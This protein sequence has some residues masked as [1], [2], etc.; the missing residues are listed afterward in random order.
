M[1]AISEA[2]RTGTSDVL[3]IVLGLGQRVRRAGS[4]EELRFIIVNETVALA[5]Y[6]QAVLWGADR[7]IVAVSGVAT[8]ERN[9]PFAL[10]TDRL[11]RSIADTL[12]GPR[13]LEADEL[14]GADG[15]Q[16]GEFLPAHLLA[17][18]LRA[19]DGKSLGILAFARPQPWTAA[20]TMFLAEVSETYALAWAWHDRPTLWRVLRHRFA[21][22]RYRWWLL[23]AAI[24]VLGLVPV[25]LSVLAPGDVVARDPAAIRAPI[26]GVIDHVMIRPNDPIAAGQLLFELDTTAVRG[27]LEVARQALATAKAEY[28]QAA[29]QSFSDLKA[30]AQLGILSG[31]IG[32]RTADIAYLTGLLDR[33]HIRAP[34]AGVAVL[35]DPSEWAGRPVSIGEKVL[36]IADERD[37]ELEG[38]L[39]P[40]DMIALPQDSPATLFLNVDPLHPVHAALRYVAY[41]GMLLPDGT[42]AHR[43]RA[44]ITDPGEK[45]RLGLKGTIRLDSY[46]VP[47]VFWLFRRPWAVVRQTFG[48]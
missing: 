21:A 13:A 12:Q 39:A 1:N 40:G 19:P 43:L 3:S 17:V 23:G 44:M 8:A 26:E 25:R 24:V 35:D 27:K 33:S 31:R 29:L 41:E 15:A 48:I 30:K 46:R 5:P 6:R 42:L 38:W 7:G 4:I 45:P 16:W 11:L 28:E 10:W 9:T 36:A 2:P 34:R 32:E 47:L 37:T 18:P 14:S 22:V 20:E